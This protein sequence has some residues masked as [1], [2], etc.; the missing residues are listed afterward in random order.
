MD[1]LKCL[2]K[3][4]GDSDYEALFSILGDVIV[5]AYGGLYLLEYPSKGVLV[6]LN[7]K[8]RR[9]ESIF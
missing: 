5:E 9:I 6:Y 8:G 7:E 3:V 1:L 4:P 2:G